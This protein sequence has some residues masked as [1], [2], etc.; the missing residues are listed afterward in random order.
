MSAARGVKRSRGEGGCIFSSVAVGSPLL[1]CPWC[2]DGFL[3]CAERGDGA[4]MTHGGE[5]DGF[6]CSNGAACPHNEVLVQDGTMAS[7]GIS[8]RAL[9]RRFFATLDAHMQNCKRAGKESTHGDNRQVWSIVAE[10]SPLFAAAAPSPDCR[11][12]RGC[13]APVF[14][15]LV[16]EDCNV[17][18]FAG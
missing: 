15:F 7:S 12:L 2:E 11:S 14:Y 16:C 10:R 5:T 6:L 3:V 8:G 1:R 17:R 18:E 13:L 9:L 4:N